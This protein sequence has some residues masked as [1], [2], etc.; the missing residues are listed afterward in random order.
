MTNKQENKKGMTSEEI[1]A[2]LRTHKTY[3]SRIGYL[4]DI[5]ERK[6]FM[7]N[8]TLASV[9]R[10]VAETMRKREGTCDMVS[11]NLL[12]YNSWSKPYVDAAKIYEKEGET[13]LA[14]ECYEIAGIKQTFEE[15]TTIKK[16]RSL[17][18]S[19]GLEEKVVDLT[20]IINKELESDARDEEYLAK[21][22]LLN[23][24]GKKQTYHMR[25]RIQGSIH[26][27]TNA[28]RMYEESQNTQKCREIADKISVLKKALKS[29]NPKNNE[30]WIVFEKTDYIF[31]CKV[32]EPGPED[33]KVSLF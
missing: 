11:Y 29:K 10:V 13:A 26:N 28:L 12:D 19:I 32:P 16:A 8:L 33:E 5:L 20:T 25:E 17:Y 18:A 4:H 9:Y 24:L 31:G 14:A 2:H 23:A 30:H 22:T 7:S 6:G 21:N 1:K 27:F 15:L 3:S